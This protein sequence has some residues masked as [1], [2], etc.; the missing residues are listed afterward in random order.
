[1]KCN[2][3]GNSNFSKFIEEDRFDCIILTCGRCGS[4][5]EIYR[6]ATLEEMLI[7]TGCE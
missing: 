4:I 3:C 5:V 7:L 2:V 6:R 1:M